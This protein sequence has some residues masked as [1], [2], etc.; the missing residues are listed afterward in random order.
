MK[1]PKVSHVRWRFAAA[2][3]A[4]RCD[5]SDELRINGVHA[6]KF[7][8]RAYGLGDKLDGPGRVDMK[9]PTQAKLDRVRDWITMAEHDALSSR[10]DVDGPREAKEDR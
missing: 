7:A 2:V 1:K 6:A 5:P 10:R 8:K 9:D 3:E 4:F